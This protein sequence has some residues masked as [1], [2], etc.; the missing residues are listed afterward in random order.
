MSPDEINA[1]LD[2]VMGSRPLNREVINEMAESKNWSR[3]DEIEKMSKVLPQLNEDGRVRVVN[4][5]IRIARTGDPAYAWG[6]FQNG[7]ITL[8]NKAARGTM[9]HEAFHFVT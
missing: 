5:L 3:E 4:G 9:Y 6:Q 7:V 8:S 1:V 2:S